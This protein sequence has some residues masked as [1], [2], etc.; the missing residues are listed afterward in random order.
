M[1]D[2]NTNAR[3]WNRDVKPFLS[4]YARVDNYSL[5]R[6]FGSIG[7]TILGKKWWTMDF[8]INCMHSDSICDSVF[9]I[10]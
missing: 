10:L 2:P 4:E 5:K 3:C 1:V 7:Y 6:H 8:K 9:A